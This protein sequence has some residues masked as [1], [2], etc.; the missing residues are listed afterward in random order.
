MTINLADN[1]PRIAYTVAQGATQQTFAVPFEFFNDPDISVYVDGVLKT[2]GTHYTLTG[3][4]GSTGNVVFVT[5]TPPA[6]QQV[7]GAT[8]GSRVV[9]FRATPLERTSDFSAGADINRAALNEQLDILT[10]MIADEDDRIDRSITLNPYDLSATLTLPTDRASKVLAFD[11]SGNVIN[12]PTIN[13]VTNAEAYATA[14]AASAASA[15]TTL[16]AT[17]AVYDNF[18]DRYLGPKSSNPTLDNDGNALLTGALYFNTVF[19]EMRVYTGSVWVAAY[20][21]LGS[22]LLSANNLSDVNNAATALGN[23]GLTA[24]AAEINKLA[25]T[26]AGLTSTEL[27]YVDGVTSA[28]QTQLNAKAALASPALTGTP[29]APTAT[30]ADNTT[31]IATTAFVTTA[32]NLKAN[33]ASPTFTGTPLAPTATVGTNTTQIATTAFVLAN[34]GATVNIQ[35][36]TGSGTYTPTAG[37]KWGIAFVTGGG[38]GSAGITSGTSSGRGGAGGGGTAIGLLDLTTLGAV[39]AT[40]GAGGTAG[41][42]APTAGGAGGNSTLSTLTGGGGNNGNSGTSGTTGG[43]ASGGILN[44]TGGQSDAGSSTGGGGGG[45]FWGTGAGGSAAGANPASGG[46]SAY[47]CGA[48]GP[49]GGSTRAGAAGAAGVIMIMEFK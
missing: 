8:G 41:T 32:D 47:G 44:L 4:D 31:Q 18:D 39:T 34:G 24:T 33:L 11:A 1:N 13:N 35:V 14:A 21:S 10:A 25:G 40:I 9:I 22:A 3:G 36:F 7:L 5:A 48:G 29:T 28:I 43:T 12:G 30:A 16:D 2:Q 23:L 45:S 42:T 49:N 19:N 20:V 15:Q 27:G 46:S 37:Y 17:L 26:P 6:V 38:G